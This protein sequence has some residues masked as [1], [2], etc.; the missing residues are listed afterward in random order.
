VRTLVERGANLEARKSWPDASALELSVWRTTDGPSR[1]HDEFEI[2]EYLAGLTTRRTGLGSLFRPTKPAFET[3]EKI[4]TAV[5]QYGH[6]WEVDKARA[7]A[8]YGDR[9]AKYEEW[10]AE[11]HRLCALFDVP[12]P[13]PVSIHDG[14]SPITVTSQ[15]WQAQHNELW[16]KLVP[17]GGPAATVQGEVIRISGKVANEI[18]GNG[19]GNWDN[20]YRS[21]L[22]SFVGYLALGKCMDGNTLVEAGYLTE[23]LRDG[24]CLKEPV[25][26]LEQIAVE[27]VGLNPTPIPLDPPPYKR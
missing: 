3:T 14:T 6:R 1:T 10:G 12:L 11:V 2:T 23:L 8:R 13:E 25:T 16:D 21:M 7:R 4:R 5:R 22:A 17:G 20:E 15:T 18:L 26:R 24:Q 9:G 19:G 27:W